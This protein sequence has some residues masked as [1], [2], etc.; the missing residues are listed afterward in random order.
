MKNSTH[1][2]LAIGIQN[3]YFLIFINDS[4]LSWF[5]FVFSFPMSV[6]SLVPN[7]LD[8]YSGV[9]HTYQTK[10]RHPLTHS[11]LTLCYFVPLYYIAEK[12]VGT[13][14]L[15]IVLSVTLGWFSHLFLDALN[16]EGIPLGRKPI[17][18][19]HSIKHYS[20]YRANDTRILRIARIP[21]N[22]PKANNTISHIGIFL[23]SLNIAD[24]ILNKVQVIFGVM[25]I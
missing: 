15:I 4:V 24:L 13:I 14:L 12:I 21:F 25:S 10:Y 1:Y 16:P 2:F 19:P 6:I 3:L 9:N 7:I 11:P 23:V 22:D 18:S 17:Y 5:F 20:W 8:S